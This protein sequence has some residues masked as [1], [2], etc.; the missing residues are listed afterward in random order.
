MGIA[1]VQ[2]LASWTATHTQLIWDRFPSDWLFYHCNNR[3]R[4]SAN[5]NL[6]PD[7]HLCVPVLRVTTCHD[8]RLIQDVRLVIGKLK[9][10][11]ET[12]II[13]D[14][15]LNLHPYNFLKLSSTYLVSTKT[16]HRKFYNSLILQFYFSV[17]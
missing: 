4:H 1:V 10:S 3:G 15:R 2:R 9:K 13:C 11:H 6:L 14:T 12:Y 5:H 17:K 16:I 8:S 7:M